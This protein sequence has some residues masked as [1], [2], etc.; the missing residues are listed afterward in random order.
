M[1]GDQFWFTLYGY[2]ILSSLFIIARWLGAFSSV[3]NVEA[4]W[5]LSDFVGSNCCV[6][7]LGELELRRWRYA[8]AFKF[9]VSAPVDGFVSGLIKTYYQLT[10]CGGSKVCNATFASPENCIA[11]ITW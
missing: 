6:L 10:W 3:G 2:T 7:R 4:A 8:T 11:N 9:V 1:R 5:Y